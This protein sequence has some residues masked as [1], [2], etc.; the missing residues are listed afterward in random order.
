MN[1]RRKPNIRSGSAIESSANQPAHNGNYERSRDVGTQTTDDKALREIP[2]PF[3]QDVPCHRCEGW[4]R[5][6]H[7]P[8]HGIGLAVHRYLRICKE[9]DY[10]SFIPEAL[11]DQHEESRLHRERQKNA[12]VRKHWFRRRKK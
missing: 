4:S 8:M 10:T 9:C 2:E 1:T 5:T 7:N 3:R 11:V 12:I 6:V